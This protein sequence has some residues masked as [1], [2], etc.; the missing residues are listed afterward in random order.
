MIVN[1]SV[2][3][4]WMMPDMNCSYRAVQMWLLLVSE[5]HCV[6]IFLSILQD[7]WLMSV[8]CVA[9]HVTFD[10]LELSS[11]LIAELIYLPTY[12]M[13]QSPSREAN[14]FSANQEIPRILWN[15]KVHYHISSC[16]LSLSWARSVQSI[17]PHP[18]SW[19]PEHS[20]KI[21]LWWNTYEFSLICNN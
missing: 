5:I 18:T 15:P 1:L 4:E 13:E 11:F 6:C 8:T 20:I 7:G 17:P 21:G 9:G 14:R 2:P 12:S 3:W 10:H 16:H 19:R